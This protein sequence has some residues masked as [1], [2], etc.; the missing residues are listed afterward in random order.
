MDIQQVPTRIY[1]CPECPYRTPH[2]WVLARHLRTQHHLLKGEAKF[3]AAE[4]EYWL[5]PTQRYYRVDTLGR[6]DMVDTL[7]DEDEE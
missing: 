4:S 5:Q 6:V 3:W 2:R 7:E 1:A